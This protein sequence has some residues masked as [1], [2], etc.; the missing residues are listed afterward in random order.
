MK[1]HGTSRWMSQTHTPLAYAASWD[2]DVL[3]MH[4]AMQQEDM[5]QF[6]RAMKEDVEGKT[7]NGNWVLVEQS[8]L[9]QGT[10]I[11]PCVWAMRRKQRIMDGTVYKWKA[12]LNVYGGKQIHGIDYWETYAPVAT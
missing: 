1:L 4:E 3:Y 6:I 12:R 7:I 8:K 9:P 5:P 11:L 2:P 10:Q